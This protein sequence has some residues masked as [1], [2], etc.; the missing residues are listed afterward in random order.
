MVFHESRW[1]SC[2][3]SCWSRLKVTI[4]MSPQVLISGLLL[5]LPA[6][7]HSFKD[8]HGVVGHSVTLPCSYRVSTKKFCMCW[9]RGACSYNSCGE[10]LIATDGYH[11][12]YRANNRYQLKG[13]L[14][15]GNMSLTILNLTQSDSGHYCCGLQMKGWYHIKEIMTT[16]LLVQPVNS[17]KS[18][19]RTHNYKAHNYFN[20][21]HTCTSIN[22][23]LYLY[24]SKTRLTTFG[25]ITLVS[26]CS[27]GCLGT[28]SVDQAGLELRNPPA[29]ASQ[30]LGLK[31]CATTTRLRQEAIPAWKPQK[32]LTKGFYV[33]L[34]IAA[35][36]LTLLV[37]TVVITSFP[38]PKIRSLQNT[39]IVRSKGEDKVYIIE[40]TSN[41]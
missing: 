31:V 15:Q 24:S 14:L 25:I 34:S 13:Q 2:P 10:P 19:K 8:V 32:N 9:G 35:L 3:M 21:I 26:L 37:S 5:L 18:S 17:Y 4:M 39:V 20:K 12:Q 40:G 1:Y 6:A 22:Q 28:H 33:G 38:V 23:S 7:V 16:L 29:S 36:L 11:I 30:V 27:P 41:S